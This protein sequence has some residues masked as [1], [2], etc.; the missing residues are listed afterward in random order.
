MTYTFQLSQQFTMT[1]PDHM[2]FEEVWT[3]VAVDYPIIN[4]SCWRRWHVDK[5]YIL[6]TSTELFSGRVI[7]EAPWGILLVDARYT[8]HEVGYLIKANQVSYLDKKILHWYL[9]K[10]DVP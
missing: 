1:N 2:I 6:P 4:F 8:R 7:K 3:V 5:E 9:S 10:S